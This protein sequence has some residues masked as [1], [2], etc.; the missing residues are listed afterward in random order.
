MPSMS[1]RPAKPGQGEGGLDRDHEADG[2]QQVGQEGDAG[3]QAGE[4]VVDDHEHQDG[5]ERQ[6]DGDRA[7]ADRVPPQGRT[8][9]VLADGERLQG[10]GQRPDRSSLTIRSTSVRS[11]LPWMM[12]LPRIGSL[13][14]GLEI[15]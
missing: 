3:D 10:G 13:T 4:A 8:H 1:T 12:P 7:G 9:G 14:V 6:E 5:R 15:R 2:E 11:N